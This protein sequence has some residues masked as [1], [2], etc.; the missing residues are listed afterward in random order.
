MMS[1]E[2]KAWAIAKAANLE[3]SIVSD[4]AEGAMDIFNPV[5]FPI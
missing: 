1:L 5:S 2:E 3:P 4:L